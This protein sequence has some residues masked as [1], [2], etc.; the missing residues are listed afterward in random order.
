MNTWARR[1]CTEDMLDMAAAY[2]K[3]LVPA[4]FVLTDRYAFTFSTRIF[5]S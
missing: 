2:V 4:I 5:N 1:P 3:P